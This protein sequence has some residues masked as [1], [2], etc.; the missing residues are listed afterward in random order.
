MT[1]KLNEAGGSINLILDYI[2]QNTDNVENIRVMI[3]EHLTYT[4]PYRK[5]HN[6]NHNTVT[7]TI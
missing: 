4:L 7:V 5:H 6:Y 2:K 3:N 1:N